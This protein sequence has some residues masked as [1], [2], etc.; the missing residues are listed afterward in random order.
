[1]GQEGGSDKNPDSVRSL[2]TVVLWAKGRACLYH[3]GQVRGE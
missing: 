2:L 1:M 3:V